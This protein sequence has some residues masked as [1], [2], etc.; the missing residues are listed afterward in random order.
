VGEGDGGVLTLRVH[1]YEG[2]S[3]GE[4]LELQVLVLKYLSGVCMC[5][6]HVQQGC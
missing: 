3:V 6:H 1:G 2:M 4:R 5:E